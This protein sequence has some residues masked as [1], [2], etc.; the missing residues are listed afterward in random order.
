MSAYAWPFL[1]AR[2]RRLGYR[3]LLAPGFLIAAGEH[4]VLDDTVVPDTREDRATVVETETPSG[5]RISIVHATHIVTAED[6]ADPGTPPAE[7]AP[8]D[9]HSRPLQLIYGFVY[10]GGGAAPPGPDDLRICREASLS[11][12]RRFLA[13]E[14]A[15][16]VE[17]GHGFALRSHGDVTEPEEMTPSSM[18][19]ID[20]TE[21]ATNTKRP[22]RAG[23]AILLIGAVTLISVVVLAMTRLTTPEPTI[24]CPTPSVVAASQTPSPKQPTAAKSDVK[25]K[26]SCTPQPPG[27][28]PQSR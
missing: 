12:Y 17:A 22:S 16:R 7:R 5:R 4:G 23:V 18:P 24:P 10:V 21:T 25:P 9:T 27:E 13:D 11:A 26:K 6:V 8:R 15:F 3:T 20:T 1:V 19:G 28:K 2:G 14:E